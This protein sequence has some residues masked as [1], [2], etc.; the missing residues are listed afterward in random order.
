[1]FVLLIQFIELK[2]LVDVFIIIIIN[3]CNLLFFSEILLLYIVFKFSA[4][5]S[6]TVMDLKS[7]CF[8]F[9]L[10]EQYSCDAAVE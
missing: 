3:I 4:L 9:Y 2:S 5:L 8:S 6:K 1:M 7:R 10:V